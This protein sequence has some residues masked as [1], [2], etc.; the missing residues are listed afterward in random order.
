MAAYFKISFEMRI[1]YDQ[2]GTFSQIETAQF[3]SRPFSRWFSQGHQ[4]IRRDITQLVF[5]DSRKTI[6]DSTC[7]KPLLS[8]E[9]RNSHSISRHRNYKLNSYDLHMTDQSTNVMTY[10]ELIS[11]Y[12]FLLPILGF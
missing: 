11:F 8:S 10:I 7:L 9:L 12:G 1:S 4:L 5:Q 3:L 6:P 2:E